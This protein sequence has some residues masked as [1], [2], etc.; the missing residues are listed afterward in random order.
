[1]AMVLTRLV[2]LHAGKIEV[3]DID[4]SQIDLRSLRD[5]IT[6]IPQDPTLFTG[7]LRYN[8]DPI[9][10]LQDQEIEALAKKVGLMDLQVRNL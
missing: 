7:T 1:M 5:K 9:G 8:I 6:V 4:I 2:E 3:D 10:N